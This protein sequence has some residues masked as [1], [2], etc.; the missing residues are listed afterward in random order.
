MRFMLM[1]L[2]SL[3][4]V[5]MTTAEGAEVGEL[6][7]KL[8]DK[9]SDPRR[10]AAKDL[11]ELGAEARPAVTELT[12]ALKDTDLYV[13]RYSAEALGNIGPDAKGAVTALAGAMNDTKK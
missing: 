11:G 6:I 8:K 7:A 2:L 9:D 12:K 4:I 13:R 5:V 3:S 1:G 10:A